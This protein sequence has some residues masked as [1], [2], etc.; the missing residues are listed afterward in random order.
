MPPATSIDAQCNMCAVSSIVYIRIFLLW[1]HSLL[2]ILLMATDVM[3]GW[4]CVIVVYMR[5]VM[6]VYLDQR[7]TDVTRRALGRRETSNISRSAQ[8]N[9]RIRRPHA[10]ASLSLSLCLSDCGYEIRSI[11]VT[12]FV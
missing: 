12:K 1:R 9:F 10:S 8:G 4:I 7:T 2:C 5:I 11:V 6:R 3:C